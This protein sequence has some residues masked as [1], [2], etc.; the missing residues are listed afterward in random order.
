MSVIR[1]ASC[2]G[3]KGQVI[4]MKAVI[5]YELII[6]DA[7]RSALN[8]DTPDEQINEFIQFFGKHIGSDRIY[9]F[10]DNLRK[11]VTNNTYEWCADGVIPQIEQLQN[12]DMDM[13]GWWYDSFDR[14]ECIVIPDLEAIREQYPDTYKILSIQNIN[15]VAIS[16]IRYKDEIYGFFGVDNPPKEDSKGLLVFLEMIGT[17][18]ISMMKMRN[19]FKKSNEDARM[20]SYQALAGIYMSMHLVNIQTGRYR[21]IKQ[22]EYT[23][24]L[25]RSLSSKSLDNHFPQRFEQVMQT[26]A[27]EK[28]LKNVLEFANLET[29]EERFE[30]TN[31]LVDEFQ[32]N[33][34]GW[35]RQ[36]FIKVDCDKAGRLWHVLYCMEIID[37]EK[38]RENRLLYLSET[39]RMTG[40][41]N[42]GSGESKIIQLLQKNVS[43]LFCILDCDKFKSINDTYGHIV[44]DA[45]IVAV[46]EALQNSCREHDIVM[47]L[48]GDEFALYIPGLVDRVQ[49]DAFVQRL[50]KKVST[51]RI[52]EMG[53]QQ[54]SISLGGAICT[55][56]EHV[57]FDQLYREADEA[58]YASKKTEG[59]CATIY[60]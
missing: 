56:R 40:V 8:Y 6:N 32:S 15:N 10:E 24:S 19:S 28:D 42:R 20:S 23:K 34:Y 41:C 52:P 5:K 37:E 21:T 2:L 55:Q 26:F 44:G 38:K 25:S 57:T 47:R 17:F 4:W 48:G 7:M 53:D 58:M 46:A 13:I 14:G 49:A 36:R 39:D 51:I 31:A 29:L 59:Y 9:I 16:P 54:I 50:L 33:V 3:I 1:Q 45:V 22:S 27:T 35:C 18:L 43:G 11:H 30:G 12:V 60:E